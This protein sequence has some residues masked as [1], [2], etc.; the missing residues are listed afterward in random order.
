V[1]P[2]IASSGYPVL[3]YSLSGE[4]ADMRVIRLALEVLI[5]NGPPVLSD[6]QLTRAEVMRDDLLATVGR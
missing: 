2:W 4:A 3:T 5:D 1:T 6:E